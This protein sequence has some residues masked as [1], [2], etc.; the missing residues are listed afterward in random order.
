MADDH[1]KAPCDRSV[2][3]LLRVQDILRIQKLI[4]ACVPPAWK[5]SDSERGIFDFSL[6]KASRLRVTAPG[7]GLPTADSVEPQEVLTPE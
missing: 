1:R 6:K 3:D 2:I 7:A 5:R 4:A